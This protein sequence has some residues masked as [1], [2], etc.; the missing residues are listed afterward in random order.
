[1]SNADSTINDVPANFDLF[2]LRLLFPEQSA[3]KQ[4]YVNND[5]NVNKIYKNSAGQK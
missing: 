3:K 1:M 2:I 5:R 4:D